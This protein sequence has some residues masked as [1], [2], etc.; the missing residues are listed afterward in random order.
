MGRF[1]SQLAALSSSTRISH[2]RA[3]PSMTI[4]TTP[5]LTKLMKSF[6]AQYIL[7]VKLASV[8]IHVFCGPC[9]TDSF[10][11]QCK[12]A[13]HSKKALADDLDSNHEL[14]TRCFTSQIPFKL[15][16]FSRFTVRF[17][18]TILFC[19]VYFH[20]SRSKVSFQL[21]STHLKFLVFV[22]SLCNANV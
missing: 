6:S 10:T 7:N 20:E 4:K 5:I 11:R 14:G 19:G 22:G 13:A 12:Y 18:I 21:C 2:I 17:T 1:N 3:F 16:I 15:N 8:H 9:C